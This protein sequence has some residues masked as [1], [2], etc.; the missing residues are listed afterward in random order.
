MTAFWHVYAAGCW[1]DIAAE[2]LLVLARAGV[3]GPVEAHVTGAEGDA[4]EL[5]ALAAAYRV[6]VRVTRHPENRFEYPTL[7]A[8]WAHCRAAPTGAAVLYFHTKNATGKG[9]TYTKWRWAM[10]AAVV[11]PWR[12]RLADLERHDA[13]GF[14][15]RDGRMFAGNFWWA[16]TDWVRRLPAPVPTADRFAHETWLFAAPGIRARSLVSEGGDPHLPHYYPQHGDPHERL[17]AVLLCP[18][19]G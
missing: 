9:P 3:P 12:D 6:P 1:Y 11:A 10:M 14:C 8:L 16:R 17:A 2:Q 13:V 4:A 5:A 19:T 18:P 7:A 15:R